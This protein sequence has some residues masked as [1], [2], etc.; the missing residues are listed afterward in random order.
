MNLT[1][2]DVMAALIVLVLAIALVWGWNLSG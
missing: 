1:W 2:L